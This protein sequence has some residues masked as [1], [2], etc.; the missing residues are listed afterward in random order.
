M[1]A[2]EARWCNYQHA[3]YLCDRSG[4]EVIL[5]REARWCNYQ[6]AD[7]LRDRSEHEVILAREARSYKYKPCWIHA[8]RADSY[9]TDVKIICCIDI[10]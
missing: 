5:A 9:N 6:R 1:L 7:Y 2:R 10:L 4:H 8:K 3:D